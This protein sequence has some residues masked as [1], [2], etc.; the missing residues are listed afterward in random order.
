LNSSLEKAIMT[1]DTKPRLVRVA[2]FECLELA[3]NI[4]QT[5]GQFNDVFAA[6]LQRAALSYN[7]HRP[8]AEQVRIET[9]GYDVVQGQFPPTL[10]EVDAIVVSGSTAS[11]YD[12]DPWIIRLAEYLKG[13]IEN[14]TTIR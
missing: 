9:T 5:R 7:H 6:W 4:A 2:V 12:Q 14:N 8:L 13:K 1:V 11:A 3:A 10:D